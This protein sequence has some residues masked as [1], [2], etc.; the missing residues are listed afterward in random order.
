[1]YV[2]VFVCVC[3]VY[4]AL[5]DLQAQ[6]VVALVTDSQ[7][8]PVGPAGPELQRHGHVQTHPVGRHWRDTHTVSTG[9]AGSHSIGCLAHDDMDQQHLS[10]LCAQS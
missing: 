6:P 2:C 8:D 1:M 9:A 4:L 10:A 3:V 5:A 7:K